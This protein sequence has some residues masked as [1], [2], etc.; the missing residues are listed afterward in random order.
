[1]SD[2]AVAK[3][4]QTAVSAMTEAELM[5]V[6]QNSLYPGAKPESIKLVLGYCKAA[7]LDP[8]LKPVHIV[9]ISVKT[10]RKK[11]NSDYD[12]YEM[13]DTIMPGIG[14]YRTQASRT[15]HYAGVSEPEFGPTKE[16]KVGDFKLEYPE[17]CKVTVNKIVDGHISPFTSNE[18][19]LENYATKSRDSK[20]PNAMWQRRPFA[21]LAKCAEAQALRKAFPE[22]GSNPTADETII[23]EDETQLIEYKTVE[24]PKAKSEMRADGG[25]QPVDASTDTVSS[26]SVSEVE[27]GQIPAAPSASH[28]IDHETGEIAKTAEGALT[29]G[30]KAHIRGKMKSASVTDDQLKTKWGI[31]VDEMTKTDFPIIKKWL[32]ESP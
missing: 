15:G 28:T 6:L 27:N 29:A 17:W 19:W 21:Q 14:L 23:P 4:E 20:I 25:S 26:R 22:L 18:R 3:I 31:T 32:A 8:M 16:L 9:P 13:R 1:M 24:Q 10:G 30:E 5:N 7:G 11:Q 2:T 12:E